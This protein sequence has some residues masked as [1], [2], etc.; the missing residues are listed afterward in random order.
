MNTLTSG[1][2]EVMVNSANMEVLKIMVVDSRS[3]SKSGMSRTRYGDMFMYVVLLA[4]SAS[5]CTGG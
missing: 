1:F 5:S 2:D 3:T 4:S